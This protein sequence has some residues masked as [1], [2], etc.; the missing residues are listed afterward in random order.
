MARSPRFQRP[1]RFR[2]IAVAAVLVV[3]AVATAG[4]G[5]RA[6]ATPPKNTALPAIS[7]TAQIGS[8]LTASSGT[9]S[10][11]TPISYAYAWFR[12]DA[13]GNHC[14]EV[15]HARSSTYSVTS[16]DVLYALRVAVTAKNSAGTAQAG[17]APTAVVPGQ[18]PAN[19]K[20][21]TVQGTPLE[22]S[23]LGGSVGQWSGTSPITYDL[24][25][26]R[27]DSHGNNCRGI[28]N[29]DH[30]NYKATADDV[31]RTLRFHVTAKNVVGS[32]DATSSATSLVDGP[33]ANDLA[34][35]ISGTLAV[36][37]RLTANVGSWRS[38]TNVAYALQWLRCDASGKNCIAIGGATGSAYN[39]ATGDVGHTV[40]LQI[41][42]KNARG[43]TT[44]S[45][46]NTAV[47]GAPVTPTG[48]VAIANVAS[49]DRLVVDR[50]T[51]SPGVIRSRHQALV[52]RFHVSEVLHGRP[53]AGALV[54]AI[55][56]P[57]GWLSQPQEVLT[58]GSGWATVV[59]SIR[60]SLPLRRGNFVVV[61]VRARKPGENLLAG[62]STRRLV[63][64]QVG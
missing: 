19:V 14:R 56:V 36:G 45:S 32:T 55:G 24:R 47:V 49:P 57:F 26:Q 8:T 4:A 23:S 25:W 34:P 11:T 59:F 41:H 15:A 27:C 40:A 21:P 29:A 7:G 42:A 51:W 48:A 33:P 62:I 35:T 1:H 58:D 52:G 64:V 31:A 12:C 17:S 39:V 60:P 43:T 20:A 44:A 50:L 37:G 38:T 16:A 5:A 2:M 9:W 10:G 22:G 18:K 63:S 46:R 54:Y 13:H 3:A 30:S 6:N 61:F 53:V 28:D